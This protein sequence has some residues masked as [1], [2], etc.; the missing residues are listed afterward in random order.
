MCGHHGDPRTVDKLVN[1]VMA[2][3]DDRSMWLI[4]TPQRRASA[5]ID[6]E[7][8]RAVAESACGT[9]TSHTMILIGSSSCTYFSRWPPLRPRVHFDLKDD[10]GESDGKLPWWSS[11]R[12]GEGILSCESSGVVDFDYGQTFWF[13][14]PEIP[15]GVLSPYQSVRVHISKDIF[16][17]GGLTYMS[18]HAI[19][20]T[21]F[22]CCHVV[23]C[24]IFIAVNMG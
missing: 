22:L 18:P 17:S 15:F 5:S 3:T 23:M 20:I 16:D 13:Q 1:G 19:K 24:L 8:E 6:Q 14:K 9:T 11:D 4:P 2:T 12:G 7:Q 21:R 10:C